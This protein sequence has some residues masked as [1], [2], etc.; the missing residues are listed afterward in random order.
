MPFGL[1]GNLVLPSASCAA[2]RQ[3]TGELEARLLRKHWLPMR[4]RLGL[5]S[6]RPGEQP[7]DIPVRVLRDGAEPI[8]AQLPVE[9]QSIFVAFMFEPPA[10]VGGRARDDAPAA[11]VALKAVGPHPKS[12][13]VEGHSRPLAA[14]E[15]VEIPVDIDAGDVVRFLSKVAHGFAI[16]ERGMNACSEYFLPKIILGETRG[17]LT[18]VG[19]SNAARD[20]DGRSGAHAIWYAVEGRLFSVFIQLFRDA[21]SQPPVYQV[22]VGRT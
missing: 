19:V 18:Y 6:R 15:R 2:C 16:Y 9:Q 13:I 1:G 11:P 17:A 10:I 21:E 14:D 4:K 20:V 3:I 12:V 5:P 7:S 22:V 8:R